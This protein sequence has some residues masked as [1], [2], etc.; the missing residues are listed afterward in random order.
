MGILQSYLYPPYSLIKIRFKTMTTTNRLIVLILLS[1]TYSGCNKEPSL[2]LENA[3]IINVETG[4]I[5]TFNLLIKGAEIIQIS[6]KRLTGQSRIDLKNNYILPPLW[7]MHVH[8]HGDKDKLK[9][10]FKY[11]VLGIRDLGAFET[12]DVDSLVKWKNELTDNPKLE[13]PNINYVGLINNDS[14]CYEGHNNVTTKKELIESTSYLSDIGSRYYKVHNCFPVELLSDL[15]ALAIHNNFVFGG[16]IPEGI[17]PIQYLKDFKN[18]NSIEH[19]SVLVRAIN[20]RNQKALGLA[21]AVE[22]L[23]GPY[24]DSLALLMKEKNISF[25]PNLTSEV[26]FIKSYPEDKKE[27]GENFLKKLMTYTKRIS[28]KGVNILAGTDTGSEFEAGESLYQELDLL[29]QAGLSNLEVLRAVT[30][31]A[32]KAN[33]VHPN[34]IKEKS[35]ANF[36]IL[37]N[38]PLLNLSALKSLVGIVHNGNHKNINEID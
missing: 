30:I 5:D 29:S 3:Q 35:K 9:A 21:E 28:D 12:T 18:I 14:T 8:V 38:N 20:F 34:L 2:V 13:Y 31:N 37:E 32:D 4:G 11:G 17:D 26:E 19:V 24:L 15:E 36:I 7:D 23:D 25:T 16:H 6:K 33:S 27:L 1:L 10:F 22:L